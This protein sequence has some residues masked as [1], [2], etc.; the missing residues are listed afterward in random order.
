MIGMLRVIIARM[1]G[2]NP[3]CCSVVR[4]KALRYAVQCKMGRMEVI[5]KGSRDDDGKE[6]AVKEINLQ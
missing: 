5:P 4:R 2:K 3:D 6:R 1:I